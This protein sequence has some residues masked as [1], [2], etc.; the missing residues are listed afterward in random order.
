MVGLNC[1]V[2]YVINFTVNFFATTATG[3]WLEE[4]NLHAKRVSCMKHWYY[5]KLYL[6]LNM[7]IHVLKPNLI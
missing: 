3:V 2:K 6:L 5:I 1:N 7:E 4:Q